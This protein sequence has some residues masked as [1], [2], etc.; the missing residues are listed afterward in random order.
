MSQRLD[1]DL[2]E[3]EIENLLETHYDEDQLDYYP[4][5]TD[6]FSPKVNSDVEEIMDKVEYEEF[7]I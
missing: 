7:E 3:E 6:L 4:V 5:S 1:D 2:T